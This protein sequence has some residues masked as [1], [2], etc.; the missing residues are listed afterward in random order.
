MLKNISGH[1]SSK[2]YQSPFLSRYLLLTTFMLSSAPI[3]V[4]YMGDVGRI[5]MPSFFPPLG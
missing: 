1:F 3:A 2:N 5:T 4:L